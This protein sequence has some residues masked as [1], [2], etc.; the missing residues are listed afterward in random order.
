MRL[1][2]HRQSEFSMIDLGRQAKPYPTPAAEPA[3]RERG[4]QKKPGPSSSPIQLATGERLQTAEWVVLPSA[5]WKQ[6]GGQTTHVSQ[7]EIRGCNTVPAKKYGR[8]TERRIVGVWGTA[9]RQTD[10]LPDQ[11]GNESRRRKSL[12]LQKVI[13]A[14]SLVQR[15][16]KS[17][18]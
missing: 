15:C 7:K 5:S 1:F 17:P 6:Q 16:A 8:P 9:P 3:R 12:S 2:C 18:I 10:L 13:R 11:T 14:R 4:R